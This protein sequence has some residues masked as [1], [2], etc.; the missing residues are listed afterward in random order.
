M[1]LW[2]YTLSAD[3]VS[4]WRACK[5]LTN[6]EQTLHAIQSWDVYYAKPRLLQKSD[7]TEIGAFYVLMEECKSV[8]PVRADGFLNLSELKVSEGFIQFYIYSE[9]RMLDGMYAYER[10]MEEI[11]QYSIRQF[12]TDHVLIPPMNKES[13]E[14]LADKLS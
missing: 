13:L 7:A 2:P 1:A 6:F 8:F 9:D 4:V 12:D 5:D 11:Q 3:K 10:F 14:N